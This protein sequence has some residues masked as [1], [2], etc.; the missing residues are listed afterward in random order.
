VESSLAADEACVAVEYAAVTEEALA[1]ESLGE[2]TLRTLGNVG[3]A[4]PRLLRAADALEVTEQSAS[5]LSATTRKDGRPSSL[6]PLF[7]GGIAVG[8]VLAKGDGVGIEAGSR[9]VAWSTPAS[10]ITA[11]AARMTTKWHSLVAIPPTSVSSASFARL[12][13]PTL[14]AL[15]TVRAIP[16]GVRER[17]VLVS[18]AASPFGIALCQVCLAQGASRVIATCGSDRGRATLS[19]SGLWRQAAEIGA[20]SHGPTV[21]VSAS[22]TTEDAAAEAAPAL[23][24]PDDVLTVLDWRE[25]SLRIVEK[26]M[27]ITAGLGADHVLEASSAADDSEAPGAAEKSESAATAGVLLSDL[28][29]CAGAGACLSIGACREGEDLDADLLRLVRLKGLV[30]SFGRPEAVLAGHATRQDVLL[31]VASQAVRL[32]ASEVVTGD[33]EGDDGAARSWRDEDVTVAAA[34]AVRV[35]SVLSRLGQDECVLVSFA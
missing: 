1:C 9:C 26:V 31:A 35:P 21:S 30:V 33:G 16:G 15:L 11:L 13:L 29:R 23:R 3:T 7:V 4:P 20:E 6:A 10:P 25:S 24:L 28:V 14:R 17:A 32:I 18:G 2:D 27:T 5:A 8:S 34:E 19:R 12:L 22:S